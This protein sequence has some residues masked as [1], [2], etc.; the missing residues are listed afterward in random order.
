MLRENVTSHS[1]SEVQSYFNI[2]NVSA[3]KMTTTRT[4]ASPSKTTTKGY[5]WSKFRYS[6]AKDAH[7][8]SQPLTL[9]A[10]DRIVFIHGRPKREVLGAIALGVAAAATTMGIYNRAQF[11]TLKQELFEVKDNIGRLFEV[12]QDFS[13]NMQAIETGFNELRTTLFY[14][15]KFNPTLFDTRL[16]HLENQLRNKLNRVTHVI[17]AA[18]HMHFAIDYLNP[19]EL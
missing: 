9:Q 14:H 17:Q 2:S 18:M 7:L 11:I 5:N 12:I 4:T 6:G 10:L 13:K 15:V 3:L 8:V 19:A 1:V 16:T